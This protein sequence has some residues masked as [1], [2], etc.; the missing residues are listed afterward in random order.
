[1][2]LHRRSYILNKFTRG[3]FNQT[4]LSSKLHKYAVNIMLK[5]CFVMLNIGKDNLQLCRT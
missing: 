4:S 1:M 3:K 2:K 5:F